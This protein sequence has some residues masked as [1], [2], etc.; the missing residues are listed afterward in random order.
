M[1]ADVSPL[2]TRVH[3]LLRENFP[4]LRGLT[5]A[6]DTP[7]LSSGLLDSFAVVTLV[8]LLEEA[9]SIDIDVE[10]IDLER[11]ET[12]RAIAELCQDTLAAGRGGAPRG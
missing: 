10:A 5:L 7:L 12:P 1:A 3:D 9:L 6:P 8:S 11:F 4:L 2:V